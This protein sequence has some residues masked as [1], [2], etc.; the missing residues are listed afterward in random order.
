MGLN[1]INGNWLQ[2]IAQSIGI[3]RNV[4]RIDGEVTGERPFD[5]F[6]KITGV[7]T[8]TPP[9]DRDWETHNF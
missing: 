9:Y 3:S 1:V 8:G 4:Q 5:K 7:N 2:T 6:G